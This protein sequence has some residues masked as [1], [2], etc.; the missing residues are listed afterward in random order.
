MSES[1][2]NRRGQGGLHT[3]AHCPLGAAVKA[4]IGRRHETREHS[5]REESP[6]LQ[7]MGSSAL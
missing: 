1:G 7:S 2:G 5:E 4:G 6:G 3:Q